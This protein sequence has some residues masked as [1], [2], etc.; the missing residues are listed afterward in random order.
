MRLH[1]W[2]I[3]AA[4]AVAGCGSV[5][6]T[7]DAGSGGDAPNNG[8]TLTSITIA[9]GGSQVHVG[10]LLTLTATGHF[11]DETTSDVT[12][13][14]TWRS[15]MESIATVAGGHVVPVAPGSATISATVGALQGN[16][17]VS[18]LSSHVLIATSF[19]SNSVLFYAP[20]SSGNIAPIRKIVGA[21]T[22]LAS[23]AGL[24]VVDEEV[25]VANSSSITVFGINNNG[26]VAPRRTITGATTQIQSARGVTVFNGEIF[27]G[28][29][30]GAP[31][32]VFPVGANGDVA[33]TRTITG[34]GTGINSLQVVAGELY[35][36]TFMDKNI[37]VYDP[38]ASGA[39]TP[40]REIIGSATGLDPIAMY[41]SDTEIFTSNVTD[42]TIRVFPLNARGN[43]AP[44]RSLT[45]LAFPG[46]STIFNNELYVSNFNDSTI[47]V[48]TV[49][50]TGAAMPSRTISGAATLLG[51]PLAVFMY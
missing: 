19:N 34:N 35:I 47:R 17:A 37:R 6:S 7:T 16:D 36:N 30:S 20:T 46:Q 9:P 42:N 32:L 23:P 10:D 33:P 50:A 43:V 14:A 38:T 44:T 39:A 5:K 3:G 15:S 26:N 4:L 40:T 25:F 31:I 27:V 8:A 28:S 13:M 29:A 11:S 41:L 1:S 18:V 24:W 12:A 21:A 51:G 2:V 48:F 49:G 45:G 22:Q